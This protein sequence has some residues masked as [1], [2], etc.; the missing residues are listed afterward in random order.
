MRGG[1]QDNIFVIPTPDK[2]TFGTATLLSSACCIPAILYL[3]F[4]WFKILEINWNIRWGNR[5]ETRL[6]EVIEG[7]NGATVGTMKGINTLVSQLLSAIEVPL[8]GAA[9]LLIVIFGERNFFS[10]QVQY[11]SEP[12][13]SIGQWAPLVGTVSTIILGRFRARYI[14]IEDP[15]IIKADLDLRR[16]LLYLDPSIFSWQKGWMVTTRRRK[17]QL[18]LLITT[19]IAQRMV[20]VDANYLTPQTP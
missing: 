20:Y 17:S 18:P 4:M 5:D 10:T 14:C 19:V 2:L 1:S 16:D 11:Q 3:V 7:T 8:F 6:D 9:V 12:I 13:K 15:R